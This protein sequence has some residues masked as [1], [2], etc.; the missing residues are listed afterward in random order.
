MSRSAFDDLPSSVSIETDYPRGNVGRVLLNGVDLIAENRRLECLLA[1]TNAR[2][3]GIIF[4]GGALIVDGVNISEEL[5]KTKAS[6]D[7]A[8]FERNQ[9]VAW[10]ARM[11]QALG[12]K[13]RVTKTVIHEW[14][15]EWH[16][17]IFIRTPAGQVSWHF[18]DRESELFAEFS[19]ANV[20]WDGHSTPQKYERIAQA[21]YE[22]T[23]R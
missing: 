9:V 15:P 14:A 10:A 3:P 5:D 6:R 12:Y 13:V 16:N 7:A 11:S 19:R 18:H 2:Q 4:D 8:Y 1:E 21:K 22:R 17:C 23:A 20:E